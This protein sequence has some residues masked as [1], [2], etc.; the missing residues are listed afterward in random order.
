MKSFGTDGSEVAVSGVVPVAAIV[1]V[2]TTS[3]V[4]L[5]VCGLVP[6]AAIVSAFPLG[7]YRHYRGTT[8]VKPKRYY[9]SNEQ[10]VQGRPCFLPLLNQT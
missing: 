1:P 3:N 4:V 5:P 2:G 9:P 10:H 6:V 7:T 8:T